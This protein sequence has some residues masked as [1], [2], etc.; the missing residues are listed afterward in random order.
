MVVGEMQRERERERERETDRQTDRHW[1]PPRVYNASFLHE[2]AQYTAF[3]LKMKG[4]K[5][6]QTNLKYKKNVIN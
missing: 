3:L 1:R 4:C 2:N 6:M 5:K